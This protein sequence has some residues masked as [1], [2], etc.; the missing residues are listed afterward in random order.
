MANRLG[1][2]LSRMVDILLAILWGV[3]WGEA[4]IYYLVYLLGIDYHLL[5]LV[6]FHRPDLFL[7][8]AQER[9]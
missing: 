3:E 9:R 8:K 5:S 7:P 2:F 1:I 6:R 4:G